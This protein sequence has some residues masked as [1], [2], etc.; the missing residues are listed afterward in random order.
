ML[1]AYERMME[2]W[3]F[4]QILRN[5]DGDRKYGY[6][7][8]LEAAVLI[9]G[10]GKCQVYSDVPGVKDVY[11]LTRRGFTPIGLSA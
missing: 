1:K 7:H 2:R 4:D 5:I 6:G 8:P 9:Y 10:G 11:W 3:E